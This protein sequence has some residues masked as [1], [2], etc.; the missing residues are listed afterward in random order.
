MTFGDYRRNLKFFNCKFDGNAVAV[1]SQAAN[2]TRREIGQ[3]GM[4]AEAFPAIDVR[5]VHLDKWDCHA[6]QCITQ[7]HAG[8]RESTGIDDDRLYTLLLCCVYAVNQ[9]AFV[10]ALEAVQPCTGCRGLIARLPLDFCQ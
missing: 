5:N 8:V 2:Y 7:C 3:V 9:F 10:I 4:V 6:R 1:G